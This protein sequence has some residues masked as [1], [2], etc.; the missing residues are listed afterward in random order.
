MLWTRPSSEHS[1]NRRAGHHIRVH[2]GAG[3]PCVKL[4]SNVAREC[5]EDTFHSCISLF[6]Q[7]FVQQLTLPGRFGK[8]ARRFRQTFFQVAD[9]QLGKT[10]MGGKCWKLNLF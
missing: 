5:N 7:Y 10:Y 3:V 4:L 2:C 9:E 1:R 6:L 8:P